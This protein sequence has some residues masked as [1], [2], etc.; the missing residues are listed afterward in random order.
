M[1][2]DAIKP[3]KKTLKRRIGTFAAMA[4]VLSAA[5]YLIGALITED[6]QM[7]YYEK[8]EMVSGGLIKWLFNGALIAGI[9]ML[10][11][12]VKLKG[13][14]SDNTR[15]SIAV[16]SIALC[17]VAMFIIIV[18]GC[19][20]CAAIIGEIHPPKPSEVAETQEKTQKPDQALDPCLELGIEKSCESNAFISSGA[21]NELLINPY[22]WDFIKSG[23]ELDEQVSGVI[24]WLNSNRFSETPL[25]ELTEDGY[26]RRVSNAA[27]SEKKAADR[28]PII[29][30]RYLSEEEKSVQR[31]YRDLMLQDNGPIKLRIEADAYGKTYANRWQIIKFYENTGDIC[32]RLSEFD[33]ALICFQDVYYWCVESLLIADTELEVRNVLE[34]LMRLFG[35]KHDRL[36]DPEIMLALPGSISEIQL[37]C[38]RDFFEKLWERRDEY[39]S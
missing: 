35:S 20:W 7:H 11:I 37:S 10:M 36:G 9:V 2:T 26:R 14:I 16:I 29:I 34:A 31:S 22:Q 15:R 8:I 12:R 17:N 32:L 6:K 3:R 39:I 38:S 25:D 27:N 1:K 28:F 13:K 4:I 18:P 30:R 23:G 33:Q 5:A 24:N 21:S 19:V